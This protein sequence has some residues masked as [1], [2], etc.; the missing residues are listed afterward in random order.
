[1]DVSE[2]SVLYQKKGH[3][4]GALFSVES[5]MERSNGNNTIVM[6][7]MYFSLPFSSPHS[8]CLPLLQLLVTSFSAFVFILC[9][10]SQGRIVEM[11]MSMQ[12]CP[13]LIKSDITL[14]SPTEF[15]SK[16]RGEGGEISLIEI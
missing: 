3:P 4:A 13:F 8:S 14:H 6:L 12:R 11:T 9:N 5:G 10:K 15:D 16:G 7:K 2:K 1:M